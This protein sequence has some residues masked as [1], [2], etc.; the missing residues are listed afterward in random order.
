MGN[1]RIIFLFKILPI[2]GGLNYS[3]ET[4]DLYLCLAGVTTQS[5]AVASFYR[6]S[7]I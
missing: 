3:A 5:S 6:N 1:I 4:D 7:E 2:S